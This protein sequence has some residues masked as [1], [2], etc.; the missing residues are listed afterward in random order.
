[1]AK[2]SFGLRRTSR[3]RGKDPAVRLPEHI[4][5]L[6]DSDLFMMLEADIMSAQEMLSRSR[7]ATAKDREAA[8]VWVSNHLLSATMAC[9]EMT[10][11]LASE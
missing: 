10:S 3:R 7:T 9:N 4:G 11:R 6:P 5:R 1:V 8:M 2:T